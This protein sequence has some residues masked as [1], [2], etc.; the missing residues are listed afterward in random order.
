MKFRVTI[1]FLFTVISVFSQTAIS[2]NNLTCEDLKNPLGID[3]KYPRL[4]W[5]ISSEKEQVVQEAYQIIVSSSKEKLENGDAD[6]WDSGKVVSDSSYHVQYKGKELKDKDNAF[7]K[8]K[9]WTNHGESGWS[10]PAYWSMGIMDYVGWKSTRWIGLD[11]AMPW[12]S[13]SKFS[14]LSARYLRKN[15]A[16]KQKIKDAKIYIMGL[17]LYELSLNGNK[18]GNQQ[19]A[20][21][22]TDYTKNV[23]Y[24]VFDVT[25]QLQKGAN[26]IGT[27]LGNGRYFTMRQDYKP[28]K[29]KTFGYPKL[30]LQLDI[31]YEDGS[32]EIIK[33]DPTWKLMADGPIRTNNEYDGEEYDARKEMPGWNKPGFD[34]SGWMNATYV[35]EPRGFFEAQMTPNMAIKEEVK[36]VSIEKLE[37]GKYILDMGQNM[38][39]WLALNTEGERGDTIRLRFAETLDKTGNLYRDNLRDAKVTDEYILKGDGIEN[40]EPTF[41]FHGFRYVEITG[42]PG[43]PKLSDFMGKV[44]YDDIPTVGSFKCSNEIMNQI[45]KN[46]YWGI[47]SNYKGMPIDCPQRNERQPWLGDRTTGAYGESFLFDNAT[48][49]SKWL[50]DIEYAQTQ[51]GG[52]P[53]VAPAFWRYYGDDVTWPAAFITIADMLYRQYGDV[54][55]ITKHYPAMK[56]WIKYM[57]ANYQENGLI[58]KDR[59]GDW[60][61]P[62]ESLELIHSED[63]SRQTNGTLLASAYYIHLLDLM[64]NFAKIIDAE[65]NDINYYQGLS[66]EIKKVFNEKFLGSDGNYD[67]G[68]V[69][70][71]LLPLAFDIAPEE[72]KQQVFKNITHAIEGTYNSHISTGVIGAQFLMRTLTEYGRTDLAYALASNKTYPSWGY[73][74]ENG[75]TTI[76]ELWNGNTADPAMNSQNHVMLL[77]DLMIWYFEDIAGIKSD[78]DQPAFK[79]IIM[80]P[81]FAEDLSFVNASYRSVHGQIESK[82]R[83]R[84]KKLYWDIVVPPN[85]SASVYMPSSSKKIKVN[86]AVTNDYDKKADCKVLTLLSGHYSLEF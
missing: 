29:I 61:V 11:K 51:D 19:L 65:S 54:R 52:I 41:V 8:V 21:V 1:F 71:N 84:G 78:P 76:W 38:A 42:Y 31:L 82:W 39:G 69:T 49:Y 37:P 73:M 57:Q 35:Q 56:K 62:P 85:T 14:R 48:L 34:D 81:S 60:C 23:K 80:K 75:A 6:L 74:A 5:M 36:P 40:W 59:Y 3:V 28:Y 86:G 53:D 27:I 45:F 55:T 2:V 77:G 70:A 44:I 4:S 22:P 30:A 25:A 66:A 13:V 15:F 47:R 72:K 83:K 17:G 24:N 58:T 67:N 9:I 64:S 26:V 32:H 79:H 50:D 63:P 68:T 16:V 7:W 12:D 10:E 20:P 18:I 33:T 43:E 46:A